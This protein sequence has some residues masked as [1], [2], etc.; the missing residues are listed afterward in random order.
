[1]A[2]EGATAAQTF[3]Q[4]NHKCLQRL[5]L[6]TVRRARAE[7][8][9]ERE[10]RD[11][12]LDALSNERAAIAAERVR[13][14]EER[15]AIATE[16]QR[17]K[18]DQE[19]LEAER[20]RMKKAMDA[21]IR[22]AALLLEQRRFQDKLRASLDQLKQTLTEQKEELER[23]ILESATEATEHAS[24]HKHILCLCTTKTPRK[25]YRNQAQIDLILDYIDGA[26]VT[27]EIGIYI[28][29]YELAGDTT[30]CA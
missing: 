30:C 9:E 24:T 19:L 4:L 17:L 29:S 25:L 28:L 13:V 6:S 23:R 20:A 5:S 8:I 22:R 14:Y 16:R 27:L 21:N 7:A 10:S 3:E 18:Q 12:E 26:E 1:M 2:S 15:A 11:R